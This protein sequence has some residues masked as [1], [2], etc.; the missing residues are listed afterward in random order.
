MDSQIIFDN[1]NTFII[2][3]ATVFMAYAAYQNM[4]DQRRFSQEIQ[5]GRI[6]NIKPRLV[7]KMHQFSLLKNVSIIAILP[8]SISIFFN[9]A[10]LT[11]ALSSGSG[12]S[13]LSVF[14]VVYFTVSIFF[15]LYLIVNKLDGIL[16]KERFGYIKDALAILQLQKEEEHV[17]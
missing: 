7:K 5:V 10:G 9:T 2:T 12:V 17:Y 3:A 15:N 8:S 1:T 13:N 11:V 16:H 6:V 4:R 14:S